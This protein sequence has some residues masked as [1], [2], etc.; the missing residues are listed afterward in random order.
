VAVAV[1]SC[2]RSTTTGTGGVV[3]SF[4]PLAY[5]AERVAGDHLAVANLTTPGVEP[6][7]IE[8]SPD[9]VDAV[10]SA[11]TVLELGRGFQPAVE[12]VAK[13]NHGAVALLDRI[14]VTGDDPHVWLDP[15]LL[16]RVA[17]VVVATFS[18]ID[19]A[20]AAAYAAGGAGLQDDLRALDTRYR[21]GLAQCARREIVTSH[22]AFGR[23]AARYGL[24][25][26]A[27]AGLS[28]EAEPNPARLAELA[29][30][31]KRDGVTTV[32]T[33]ELLSPRV[34]NALAREAGVDTVVLSP[35]EGLTRDDIRAGAT[36]LTVMDANLAK[37]R[38]ALH[39][40]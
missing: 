30:V 7:D 35:I 10:L 5:V 14:G 22:A 13:R 19:R 33:E 34:A 36:Y 9:Q 24:T 29:D 6:H 2:A 21:D 31:I 17:D 37:L 27:V 15:V 32:F 38:A 18:R 3:A 12:R 40:D 23:L 28:P 20:N 4:Y 39:C 25:Q 11:R 16:G 26:R 1:A 8:L